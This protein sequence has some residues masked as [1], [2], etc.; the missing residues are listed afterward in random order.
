MNGYSYPKIITQKSISYLPAIL[1][2]NEEQTECF[3]EKYGFYLVSLHLMTFSSKT[4][5]YRDKRFVP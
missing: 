1:L 5:W 4:I 3:L 2:I